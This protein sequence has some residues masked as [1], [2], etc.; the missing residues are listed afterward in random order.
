MENTIQG[1]RITPIN[2]EEEMKD[3]YLI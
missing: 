2:I 1:E 3:S